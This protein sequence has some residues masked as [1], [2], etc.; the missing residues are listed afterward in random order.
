MQSSHSFIQVNARANLEHTYL[1][2]DESL[3]PSARGTGDLS[4]FSP[5][6]MKTTGTSEH[7][8]SW[9][10]LSQCEINR[11]SKLGRKVIKE[12]QKRLSYN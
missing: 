11:L 5:V 8:Y 6:Y 12:F 9:S 1:T 3:V 2:R 10:R 4:L 7:T